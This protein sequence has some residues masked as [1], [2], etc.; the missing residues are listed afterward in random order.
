MSV[1]VNRRAEFLFKTHE[2]LLKPGLAGF[3]RCSR[4][5]GSGTSV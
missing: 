3:I 1:T 4:D 5:P 2:D